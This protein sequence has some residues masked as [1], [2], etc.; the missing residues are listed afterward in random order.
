MVDTGWTFTVL[1][2]AIFCVLIVFAVLWL[3]QAPADAEAEQRLQAD[4][5]EPTLERSTQL[6]TRAPDRREDPGSASKAQRRWRP[7]DLVHH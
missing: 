7:T 2:A 5:R 4:S 6:V 3:L 1:F